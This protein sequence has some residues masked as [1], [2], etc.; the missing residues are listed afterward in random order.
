MVHHLH[1]N[2][3]TGVPCHRA[4]VHRI[5]QSSI[6]AVRDRRPSSSVLG[7]WG[8]GSFSWK[9]PTKKWLMIWGWET[10]NWGPKTCAQAQRWDV[11]RRPGRPMFVVLEMCQDMWFHSFFSW[12]ALFDILMLQPSA[13]NVWFFT[14]WGEDRDCK[15]YAMASA[16]PRLSAL[17]SSTSNSCSDGGPDVCTS[18]KVGMMQTTWVFAGVWNMLKHVQ[19]P[20]GVEPAA[21][22]DSTRWN[23]L[24]HVE[25]SC[26]HDLENEMTIRMISGWFGDHP[27]CNRSVP[28]IGASTAK[29]ALRWLRCLFFTSM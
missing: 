15:R 10:C 17:P 5:A 2:T 6:L 22:F 24:K 20:P 26:F 29:T 19:T 9:I 28:E 16:G 25:T 1:S 13:N 27:V 21:Q 18:K 23:T 7:L 4:Y 12:P 11:D 8:H 3:A 14:I